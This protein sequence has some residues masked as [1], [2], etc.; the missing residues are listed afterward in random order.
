MAAALN[1]S[2]GAELLPAV[3]ALRTVGILAELGAQINRLRVR[4]D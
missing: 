2:R 3:T 1:G 4:L